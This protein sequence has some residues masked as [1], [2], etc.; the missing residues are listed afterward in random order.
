MIFF[1]FKKLQQKC[2]AIEEDLEEAKRKVRQAVS[3]ITFGLC[4]ASA[5]LLFIA[6]GI[7]S[8]FK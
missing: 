5:I 6:L 2:I 1:S 7:F 3:V 4:L 8:F